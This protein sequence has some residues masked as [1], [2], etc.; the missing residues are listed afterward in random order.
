M[1]PCR[2]QS[3]ETWPVTFL[4]LECHQA[5]FMHPVVISVLSVLLDTRLLHL[6]SLTITLRLISLDVAGMM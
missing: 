1:K 2:A 3:R 5:A 6:P 4:S